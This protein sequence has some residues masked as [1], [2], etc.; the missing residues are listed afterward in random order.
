MATN[1]KSSLVLMRFSEVSIAEALDDLTAKFLMCEEDLTWDATADVSEVPTKNCG[2]FRVP[3]APAHTISGTGIVAANL[4]A[5][6]WSSQKL[7]QLLED[8]TTVYAVLKNDADAG[9]GIT[10]SEV[11][12]RA[13]QGYFSSVGE[14]WTT[15]DG[16]GKF[17]WEFTPNGTVDLTP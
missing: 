11:V 15:G 9:A 7:L 1:V 5:N 10:A 3:Q 4:G 12:Y 16:M 6:E 14:T 8:G 17:T 2:T 13:T